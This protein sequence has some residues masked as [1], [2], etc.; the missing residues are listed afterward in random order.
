ML[1]SLGRVLSGL[2]MHALGLRSLLVQPVH[3]SQGTFYLKAHFQILI[4][5]GPCWL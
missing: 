3:V 1:I 4:R 2:M 5:A